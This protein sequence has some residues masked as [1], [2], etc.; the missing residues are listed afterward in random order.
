MCQ[1]HS[2]QEES[3]RYHSQGRNENYIASRDYSVS[4]GDYQNA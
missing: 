3:G 4:Q 1:C 2:T